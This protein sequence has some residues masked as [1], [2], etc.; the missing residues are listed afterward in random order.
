MATLRQ[1]DTIDYIFYKNRRELQGI[2]KPLPENIKAM[3]TI[4]ASDYINKLNK[5]IERKKYDKKQK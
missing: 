3:S 5:I 1:R 2:S 4:E